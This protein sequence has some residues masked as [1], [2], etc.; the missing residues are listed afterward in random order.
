M[1]K[2][3]IIAVLFLLGLA[4][5]AQAGIIYKQGNDLFEVDRDAK[6]FHLYLNNTTGGTQN[7][8]L[9]IT[10]DGIYGLMNWSHTNTPAPCPTGTAVSH[11]GNNN[12]CSTMP[13]YNESYD[14]TFNYF[15]NITHNTT[16]NTTTWTIS[17]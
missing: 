7:L 5:G 12:T 15:K 9:N 3:I 4:V 14:T 13:T 2:A 16:T 10:N 11:I 8:V 1:K 6:E 17:I